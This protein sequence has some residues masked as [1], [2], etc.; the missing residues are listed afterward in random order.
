MK[1]VLLL[2]LIL[3]VT[4]LPAQVIKYD[5]L[6]Q[7]K[8]YNSYYSNTNRGP[9][10]VTYKLYRGGGNSSRAKMSFINDI[11]CLKVAN[12]KDYSHSGYD[13]GHMANAEDFAYDSTCQ[14]LTFRYYNCVPQTAN[15]N[16]GVWKHYESKIRKM[17]NKDSLFIICYNHFS[18]QKLRDRVSVPDT[19]YK[20][21]FSLTTYKLLLSIGVV[22]SDHPIEFVPNEQIIGKIEEL[23]K[24]Q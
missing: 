17:S 23:I 22:N 21:V 14:Q 12:S 9:I 11:P 10:I 13:K 6:I 19:C 20:F 7:T 2:F 1:K 5:T 4:S 3:F 24:I 18:N 8:I 16:R 15:L